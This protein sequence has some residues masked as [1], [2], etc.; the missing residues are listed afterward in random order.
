MAC[1]GIGSN[2]R[3]LPHHLVTQYCYR[4]V[5]CISKGGFFISNYLNT[6]RK[7]IAGL[8]TLPAGESRM[9]GAPMERYKLGDATIPTDHTVGG[10]AQI[11]DIVG[12][13]TQ[14]RICRAIKAA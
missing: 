1:N 2:R 7:I 10:D 11:G 8:T 5:L 3:Q 4:V 12:L 13:L 9:P 6:N 14:R